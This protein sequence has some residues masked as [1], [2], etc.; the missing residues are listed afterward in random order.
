VS[1]RRSSRPSFDVWRTPIGEED[2]RTLRADV[3]QVVDSKEDAL[4]RDGCAAADYRLSG[5][6]ADR[7]CS[8]HLMRDWRMI[9]GFPAP[10]EVAV[11]L[12]GRHIH[13]SQR[14]VYERFY[15]GLGISIP[16][17]RRK[18]PPCCEETGIAPVDT[19]AVQRIAAG[20]KALAR[21]RASSVPG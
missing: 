13:G 7:F 18:K 17:V 2:Y 1:E 19:E 6:S 3:Q 10:Q 12:V 20:T 8:L 21:G 16:S 14:D 9:V 15:R 11:L 4:A 5:E